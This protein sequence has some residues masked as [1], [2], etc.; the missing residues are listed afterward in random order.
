MLRTLQLMYYY[1]SEAK[2]SIA[3]VAIAEDLAHAPAANLRLYLSLDLLSP[4]NSELPLY[5]HSVR[6]FFFVKIAS[7]ASGKE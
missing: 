7:H 4:N 6:E 3:T 1:G 5:A 2:I